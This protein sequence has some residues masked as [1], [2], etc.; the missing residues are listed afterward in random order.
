MGLCHLAWPPVKFS[1]HSEVLGAVDA[2]VCS[3]RLDAANA[4]HTVLPAQSRGSS[5]V[6]RLGWQICYRRGHRRRR[7][8]DHRLFRQHDNADVLLSMPGFGPVLAATFLAIIGGNL[9]A[10]D[11]VDRLA[12]VAGL[13]PVHAIPDGSAVVCTDRVASTTASPNVLP[14]RP[15]LSEEEPGSRI[16]YYR[17]VGQ[18]SHMNRWRFLRCESQRRG[19][20][21]PDTRRTRCPRR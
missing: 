6:I 16:Y 12:S 11:S 1:G 10:S 8:P 7:C 13:A 17:N 5:L 4:Q 21:C 9:D 2:Q 19:P 14:R 15:V 3:F 18:E 20:A